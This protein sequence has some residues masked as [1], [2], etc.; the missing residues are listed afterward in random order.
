MTD[1][2]IYATLVQME[3]ESLLIVC[4]DNRPFLRYIRHGNV[5]AS[6]ENLDGFMVKE[7][8]CG[9][10]AEVQIPK[11]IS[12]Y[13]STDKHEYFYTRIFTSML[14]HVGIKRIETEV[15]YKPTIVHLTPDYHNSRPSVD[16]QPEPQI[17]Q[18]GGTPQ[19]ET[20]E[21]LAQAAEY[22]GRNLNT[23]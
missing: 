18:D 4:C 5:T 23:M 19:S 21:L 15:T 6:Q 11:D 1:K 13:L 20:D 2:H 16:T 22:F 17:D 14:A 3:A 8:F 9:I 12:I 10:L 7:A